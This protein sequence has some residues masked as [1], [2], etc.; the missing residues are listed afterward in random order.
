MKLK[1]ILWYPAVNSVLKPWHTKEPVG[2]R[3]HSDWLFSLNESVHKSR[4]TDARIANQRVK[5]RGKTPKT[6]LIFH[7]HLIWSFQYTDI[8]TTTWIWNEAKWWVRVVWKWSSN[9]ALFHVLL[10]G[11]WVMNTEHRRHPLRKCA[12]SPHCTQVWGNRLVVH[13]EPD[14]QPRCHQPSWKRQNK[15]IAT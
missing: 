13:L 8:F 14:L 1:Q 7:L 5:S 3:N 4:E 15:L 9:A 12:V 2:E 10:P 11:R 6:L